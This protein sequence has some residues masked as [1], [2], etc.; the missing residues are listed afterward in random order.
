MFYWEVMDVRGCV[1]EVVSQNVAY[2]ESF[3]IFYDMP[4]NDQPTKA[5]EVK[6]FYNANVICVECVGNN[7]EE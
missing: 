1:H 4:K 7:C 2:R 5:V 3:I 6:R